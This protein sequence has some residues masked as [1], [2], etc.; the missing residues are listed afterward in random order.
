LVV[1]TIDAF[2]STGGSVSYLQDEGVEKLRLRS[3]RLVGRTV[4]GFTLILVLSARLVGRG[5]IHSWVL[6]SCWFAA[7]PLILLLVRWWRGTIF[8]RL[9]RIRKKT[10]LQAWVLARRTGWRSF[11]AAMLGAVELLASGTWKLLRGWG[12]RFESVRR[13][14]AYFFRREI[15]RL[16]GERVLQDRAP[17]HAALLAE[18]DPGRPLDRWLACPADELLDALVSDRDGRRVVLIV[19]ARGMGKSSLLRAAAARLEDSAFVECTPATTLADVRRAAADANVPGASLPRALLL[20]DVHRLVQPRVGGFARF[21]EL[22]AFVRTHAPNV[23]WALSVDASMWPLIRLARDFVPLF[24]AVHVLSPWTEGQIGTLVAARCEQVGI[25]ASYADLVDE[26]PPGAD[27]LDRLDALEAKRAGYQRMLWDHAAG[28]P[29]L[30]LE[31]WRASLLQDPAGGVH[32]RTLQVP[33]VAFL[34]RL[35]DSSLFVLKAVLQSAPA[36]VETVAR[37]TR[38]HPNEVSQNFRIGC[39]QGLFEERDGGVRV[40]WAWIREVTRL[41]ERRHLLVSE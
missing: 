24:D 17:L 16:R 32:V 29:G 22:M 6:S 41:L 21:D 2:A 40:T 35:P 25:A 3:L 7:I 19:G 8:G 33:D 1:D 39:A 4:V 9:E 28:N 15:E 38:M 34:D 36:A 26:L 20:D 27:E 14:H 37:V 13:V 30:A 12:S 11:A 10:A 31:A 18:L 23:A 5:T